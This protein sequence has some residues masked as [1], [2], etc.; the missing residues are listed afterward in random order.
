MI[1][2]ETFEGFQSKNP[3]YNSYWM[4]LF[5][6]YDF[7]EKSSGLV[8]TL[9]SLEGWNM[10]SYVSEK[11]SDVCGLWDRGSAGI[12]TDTFN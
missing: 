11:V 5:N 12:A 7:T 10:K 4:E 1:N 6:V 2:K 8:E 9:L 3:I